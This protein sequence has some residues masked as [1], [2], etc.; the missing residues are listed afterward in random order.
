MSAY[1]ARG[2]TIWDKVNPLRDRWP[3]LRANNQRYWGSVFVVFILSYSLPLSSQAIQIFFYLL[4]FLPALFSLRYSD[5]PLLFRHP[6]FWLLLALCT[7]A[8]LRSVDWENVLDTFKATA[9][10]FALLIAALRLPSLHPEQVKRFSLIFILVLI[11]YV[12]INAAHQYSTNEWRL[13]QRLALLFG[14]SKSVIFT[15]DLLLSTL[16]TYS[17][18]CIKTRDLKC[19]AL[20]HIGVVG[21]AMFFCKREVLFR[22]GLV[23]QQY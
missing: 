14:Q 12:L 20:A 19:M 17:W 7:Y 13:G 22:L 18:S 5:F 11:G 15:A 4:I 8:L 9:A 10:I 16:V 6:P 2:K 21:V 23:A 3:I 1:L